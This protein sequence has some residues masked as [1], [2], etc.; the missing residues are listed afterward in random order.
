MK[1]VTWLRIPILLAASSMLAFAQQQPAKSTQGGGSARQAHEARIDEVLELL[2]QDELSPEAREQMRETLQ[3]LRAELRDAGSVAAARSYRAREVMDRAKEQQNAQ[4][5]EKAAADAA[6]IQAQQK[7]QAKHLQDLLRTH[8]LDGATDETV[9]AYDLLLREHAIAGQ[10]K[11]AAEAAELWRGFVHAGDGQAWEEAHKA[12]ARAKA[13]QSHARA[14]ADHARAMAEQ[15][16]ALHDAAAAEGGDAEVVREQW[17]D[18]VRKSMNDSM[19]GHQAAAKALEGAKV[20]HEQ[21]L[22]AERSA[23]A[24]AHDEAAK[25][26]AKAMAEHAAA[27]EHHPAAAA[28]AEDVRVLIE[29]MRAEM[30]QIRKLMKEIRAQ[31][32]SGASGGGAGGMAQTNDATTAPRSPFGGTGVGQHGDGHGDGHGEGHGGSAGGSSLFGSSSSGSGQG[33]GT[34]QRRGARS[35]FGGTHGGGGTGV[36]VGGGR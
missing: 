13:E 33:S 21:A 12:F 28:Q 35:F 25:A 9:K 29:E 1:P 8:G 5:R 6:E 16:K 15:A 4:N 23:A 2:A 20:A 36:S 22:V 27:H 10:G 17:L 19:G 7:I 32:R 3:K 26:H 34:S 31:A 14:M 24:A 11:A 18:L 30:A